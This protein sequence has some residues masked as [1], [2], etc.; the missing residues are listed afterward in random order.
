MLLSYWQYSWVLNPFLSKLFLSP[1][2]CL[3][4]III[5][6][7]ITCVAN[8]SFLTSIKSCSF[9]SY[10]NNARS[11]SVDI[12]CKLRVLWFCCWFCEDDIICCF[13][14]A[15][16]IYLLAII[17]LIQIYSNII[18]YLIVDTQKNARNKASQIVQAWKKWWKIN[19]SENMD[20]FH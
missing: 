5:I 15:F 11:C 19:S 6:I 9:Y 20:Q 8:S 10:F 13:D 1:F 18:I 17:R 14:I 7:F 12:C 16:L 3:R 2:S 4:S